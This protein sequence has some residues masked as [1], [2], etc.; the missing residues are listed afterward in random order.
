MGQGLLIFQQLVVFQGEADTLRVSVRALAGSTP[1]EATAAIPIRMEFSKTV[2]RF[3][4]S[5]VIQGNLADK[6]RAMGITLMDY[7][8]RGGA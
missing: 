4:L 5:G 1:V 2:F 3:P 6:A 8:S 7:R